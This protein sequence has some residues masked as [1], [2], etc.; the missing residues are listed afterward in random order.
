MHPM[1][2][3][4]V[5]VRGGGDLASGVVAC[6]HRDGWRVIVAELAQPLV[7]RRKVAFAEAVYEG[8]V[9]VEEIS[10]R[11]ANEPSDLEQILIDGDVAV[12]ID[13]DLKIVQDLAVSAIVDC[14][15]LKE[16]YAEDNPPSIPLIGLG[17]G[18]IGGGN[19]LAVIETNRGK[20][21]GKAIYQGK[22]EADTGKPAL[23]NGFSLERV[24][25]APVDGRFDP[26]LEIG[27][28]VQA[29]QAIGKMNGELIKSKISGVIRG[30]IKEGIDIPK[31]TKVADIDPRSK[32]ETCYKISDK[33]IIIGRSVC[34]VLNRHF[35][36]AWSKDEN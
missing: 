11:L 16:K 28:I 29:D 30:L 3:K 8:R 13:P 12:L 4:R 2:L 21:L 19:C 9:Q 15:M 5:I 23:V 10:A 34:D 22:P 24:I 33:A 32:K 26:L 35:N 36:N 31:G 7:V 17:P 27:D 25:Y 18:F 14:R 20:N 6:L 1:K